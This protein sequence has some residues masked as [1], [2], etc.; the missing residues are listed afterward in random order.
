MLRKGMA[1][2]LS[3]V[4]ALSLAGCKND[5]EKTAEGT[6]SVN[7]VSDITTTVATEDKTDTTT[8]LTTT[9][10]VSDITTQTTPITTEVTTEATTEATTTLTTQATTENPPADE[11]PATKFVY[12][13]GT[14][15][16]APSGEEYLI[17]GIAFGNEIWGNPQN[18]P[19][20]HHDESSYAEIAQLGFNS[21]RFYLNYGLFEDDSNP[22]VYKQSGFD[23]LD[24]NIAWAKKYGIKLVLNMHYPQGGYQS[25]GNGMALWTDIENQNR[26][27]AL[28]K[29]IAKRYADEE[30]ILGYGLINEPVVPKLESDEKTVGQVQSL[31][32]R[33]T[34][35]IREVDKNH[36]VIVERMCACKDE[37]GNS[38]WVPG[39]FLVDGENIVYEFHAYSPHEFTHQDMEWAGTGGEIA[40]YPS[41]KMQAD[42]I[43][44]WQGCTHSEYKYSEGIWNY[45]ESEKVTKTDDY[46]VGSVTFLAANIGAGN[47]VYLDD[48][49]ITEYDKN[50]NVL[51]TFEYEMDKEQCAQM[52]FWAQDGNGSYGY[53]ADMGRSGA[54][55]IYISGT[56]SD[57]NASGLRFEMK[58]GLCYTI[59]G[60]VNYNNASSTN[61]VM[62]RIDYALAE[63]IMYL[64]KEYLEYVLLEAMEFYN[65]NNVPVYL[66]EFGTCVRSFQGRGGEQ[67]VKDMLELLEEHSINYNYHT[68]HEP[69]FGLHTNSGKITENTRNEALADIF[70]EYQN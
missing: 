67:W 24:K 54:G 48:V 2:L 32:Q 57:A 18:P 12:A 47:T 46:N 53:T 41:D 39:E 68:Y 20:V 16:Y 14:K 21:V 38:A 13:Q 31:M 4:M 6:S 34:D 19:T 70:R 9:S 11:P 43:S 55:C 36:L 30:Y 65:S 49:T 63:N 17:R 23:W 40:Y 26:L 5:E 59:S 60:W 25:Q 56:T 51:N 1:L 58:E 35:A 33:I 3:L 10:E 29:E 22:Y 62:P 7:S 8:A 45:F 42:Y 37:S 15:L 44:Y 66:G 64:D 28:W 27:I 52:G 50:G 69:S 61:R